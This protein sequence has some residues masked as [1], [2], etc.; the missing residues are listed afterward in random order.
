[1]EILRDPMDPLQENH[2]IFYH[3]ILV[4]FVAFRRQGSAHTSFA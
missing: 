4:N 2:P 1:M 3:I